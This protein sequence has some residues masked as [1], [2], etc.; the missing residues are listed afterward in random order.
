MAHDLAEARQPSSLLTDHLSI[1]I[2]FTSFTSK[3][4]VEGTELGAVAETTATQLCIQFNTILLS[5]KLTTLQV[6]RAHS[7]G[8]WQNHGTVGKLY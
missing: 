7:S 6:A 4:R 8:I 5:C 1:V 2:K 3:V